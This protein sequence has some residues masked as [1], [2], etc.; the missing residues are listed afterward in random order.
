MRTLHRLLSL[1][2]GAGIL[3]SCLVLFHLGWGI[4][5][6]SQLTGAFIG[7]GITLFAI[8]SRRQLGE[9]VEPWLG[10]EQ[11]GWMLI[12]WGAV[13]WGIGECFWRY[14][15]LVLHLSPF[16]SL[17]DV[18][19]SSLPILVFAGLLL[20]PSLNKENNRLFIILDSLIAM[21]S[22]LAIGW[23]LLLGSL[24]TASNED[25]LAKTLGLYYPTSDIALLSFVIF[26]LLRSQGAYDNVKA[27]RYGLLILGM[28]LSIFAV[29]DFLFNV[30]QNLGTYVDGTWVD[31]GWP[32]G[33]LIVGAAASLRRFFPLSQREEQAKHV[34]V[35]GVIQN[36]LGLRNLAI[37][38][39][40]AV[41][42]FVLCLNIFS[43][44][45]AT[46]QQR[47]VLVISVLII[48]A[49]VVIRQIATILENYRLA[50]RQDAVLGEL[51]LAN[52]HMEEQSR[53]ITQRNADLEKGITHLKEVHAQIA[54][55]NMRTRA[56]INSGDLLPLAG[57]FNLMVER[58][59]RNDR[60]DDYLRRLTK[61]LNDLSVALERHRADQPLMISPSYKE[62]PE[63]QRLLLALGLSEKVRI[64]PQ[65]P[66]PAR[67]EAPLPPLPR[68]PNTPLPRHT[69][70][71]PD[72][73]PLPQPG[74]RRPF[75]SSP[76]STSNR[77]GSS[78]DPLNT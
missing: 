70:R 59:S 27:R 4:W 13:M 6:F 31:L 66:A 75:N 62:F 12:G 25:L 40:V 67:F 14:Y 22:L 8:R 35:A 21:G 1:I 3:L 43:S 61:L 51:A 78:T 11:L 65:Q 29:S 37:Y 41:L 44:D 2:I 28:G 18:G 57:S 19:Y 42:F 17:A 23:A 63:I 49:L 48:V 33:L 38:V 32:L 47:P 52:Q 36:R 5:Q 64:Q 45:P 72:I 68:T 58:L 55:G 56:Q 60:A 46:I 50:D 16:P 76:P 69:L 20:Q 74:M 53:M 15:V 7:G 73:K 30:Q 39:L 54:N 77:I 9:S 24:A 71:N 34:A 10:R 26:L